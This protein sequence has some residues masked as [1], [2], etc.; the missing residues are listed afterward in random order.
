MKKCVIVI[1]DEAV[2]DIDAVTDYIHN[3]I[4]EPITA[5][6]YHDGLVKAIM[7]LSV[8]ADAIAISPYDFIQRNYGPNARHITYKK[9]TVIYVVDGDFVYIQRVISASL[10]C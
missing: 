3:E 10:V 9:M 5:R 6:R 1:S 2:K 4:K 7:K 8:Y